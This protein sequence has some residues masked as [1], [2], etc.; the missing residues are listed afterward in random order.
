MS[1][2][3]CKWEKFVTED[4]M[5]NLISLSWDKSQVVLMDLEK[6][7]EGYLLEVWEPPDAP[8]GKAQRLEAFVKAH[9]YKDLLKIIEYGMMFSQ[10]MG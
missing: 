2:T 5:L 1:I 6:T 4:E 9:N 7:D 10:E 3:D 8:D